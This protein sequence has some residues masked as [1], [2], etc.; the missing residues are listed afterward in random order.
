MQPVC[1]VRPDAWRSLVLRRAK[2]SRIFLFCVEPNPQGKMPNWGPLGDTF[3]GLWGPLGGVPPWFLGVPPW[4]LGVPP[5]FWG[6]PPWFLF[7]GSIYGRSMEPRVPSR[8]PKVGIV[9]PAGPQMEVI[10]GS[11]RRL[12]G[13][14]VKKWKL[15]PL[16]QNNLE[17]KVQRGSV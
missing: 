11:F 7:Q 13:D 3:W 14:P 9:S 5:W 12:F 15:M 4:F 1:N 16:S 8:S 2:L 17:I 10:L 6:V